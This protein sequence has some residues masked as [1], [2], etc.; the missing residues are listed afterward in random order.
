L[1]WQLTRKLYEKGYQK[2]EVL[3]LYRLIDWVMVMPHELE[4]AFD[5]K[6]LAYEEENDMPYITSIE[7]IGMEKGRQEGR[8]EGRQIGLQEGRQQGRKEGQTALIVRLLRSRLG[9]LPPEMESRLASLTLN[10]LESL[11]EIMLDFRD[12]SALQKWL[13]SVENRTN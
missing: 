10:Q 12:P 5:K 6:M 4:L 3:D 8:Q 2:Q 1:K 13:D 9:V 7:R 11:S